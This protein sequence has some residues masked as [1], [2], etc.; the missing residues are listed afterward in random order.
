MCK[1]HFSQN[2][3]CVLELK[4]RIAKGAVF[5]ELAKKIQLAHW[6]IRGKI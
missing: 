6:V 1:T 4:E 5:G 3:K 2:R